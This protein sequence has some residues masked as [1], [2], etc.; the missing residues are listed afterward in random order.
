MD[1]CMDTWVKELI[2]EFQYIPGREKERDI[3]IISYH[4]A[5]DVKWKNVS[6]GKIY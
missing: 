2:F 6:P 3:Y 1:T 4:R 5:K